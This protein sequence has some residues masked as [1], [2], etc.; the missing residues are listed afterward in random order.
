MVRRPKNSIVLNRSA[1]AVAVAAI[2]VVGCGAT[3]LT[4]PKRLD[5]FAW[6]ASSPTPVAWH[7]LHTA[8]ATLA[9]PPAWRR[10][11]ADRGAVTATLQTG[12][13]YHGYLNATPQQGSERLAGWAKF[14]VEHNTEEGDKQLVSIATAVNLPFAGGRGSCVIDDYVA[15]VGTVRYREIACYVVGQ[16]GGTVL[17]AAAP[18]AELAARMPELEQAV[19]HFSVH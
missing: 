11:R 7:T 18:V 5:A 19:S 16:H 4:T 13:A 6:F 8:S 3:S 10:A 2:A 12:H 9:Y 15:K 1:M 17:I 14:R